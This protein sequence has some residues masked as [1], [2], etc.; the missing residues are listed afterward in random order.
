MKK[1]SFVK[2]S[3]FYSVTLNKEV[4]GCFRT[5]C[6]S[7]FIFNTGVLPKHEGKGIA[8]QLLTYI[9]SQ[10]KRPCYIYSDNNVMRKKILPKVG[11]ASIGTVQTLPLKSMGHSDKM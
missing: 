3:R 8:T 4:I 9:V 6:D 2:T 7:S 1:L 5:S 10:E 11:S